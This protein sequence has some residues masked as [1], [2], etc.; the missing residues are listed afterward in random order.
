M[1]ITL[2]T[3][4]VQK[5]YM[6]YLAT[7]KSKECCFCRERDSDSIIKRKYKYWLLMHNEY[8]YD[9]V[10]RQHDLL[11]S[12][13]HVGWGDLTV[14]EIAEYNIIRDELREKYEQTIE[15][16]GAASSQRGHFHIHYFNFYR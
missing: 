9:K 7:P 2:R 10:Y 13:R 4:K 14:N 12:K 15:N 1:D 11:S 16:L 8:P 5:K 3:D 6:E